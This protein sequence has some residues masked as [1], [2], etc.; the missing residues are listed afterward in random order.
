MHRVRLCV[1][2]GGRYGGGTHLSAQA[3][4]EAPHTLLER[5]PLPPR[6]DRRPVESRKWESRK[7]EFH[8]RPPDELAAHGWEFSWAG[9]ERGD[10]CGDDVR[11]AGD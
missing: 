8:S 4:G 5:T 1:W 9:G 2:A 10:I 7:W 11:G 3:L 6:K